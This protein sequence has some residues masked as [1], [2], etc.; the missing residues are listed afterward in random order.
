MR[1][2]LAALGLTLLSVC[3]AACGDDDAVP[4]VSTG[5]GGDEDED[6]GRSDAGPPSPRPDGGSILPPADSELELPFQGPTQTFQLSGEASL[7]MLDVHLSVD[8]S[9]SID[10]EIDELQDALDDEI[11]PDLRDVVPALCVGVSR[12]EDFPRP[13]FGNTKTSAH[14]ADRPYELLTAITS[15]RSAIAAA[16]SKLDLPLGIGGDTPEAGAEALYQ[17]ATG[18][19]YELNDRAVIKPFDGDAAHGGGEI[20]G[21]GFR[22]GALH[23]V[24][25]ITDA[26]AHTPADYEADF[27]DTH[28]LDD[29]A[30][31]LVAIDARVVSI[32]SSVCEKED[33]GDSCDDRFPFEARRELEKLAYETGAVTAPDDDDECPTGIEGA[34]HEP[35]EGVCPL[36]FDVT[37]Q[38][39]GLVESFTSAITTLV[40]D[41]R[42][43]RVVGVAA[44]DPLGLVESIRPI[45]VSD[46]APEIADLLP[47]GAPDGRPDTF[48]NARA[49]APIVFE[50]RLRNVRL[51]PRDEPQV[52]RVVLQIRGDDLI[53]DEQ[54]LRIT[55]PAGTL[56]PPPD[57]DAGR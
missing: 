2:V 51:P 55:V 50:V 19:G 24:L 36:V 18:E 45:A 42:F 15:S 3:A 38:G 41:I 17:I 8:T 5:D 28:S 34:A 14:R 4:S 33:R 25:H 26:P 32:V 54:T 9:A 29:A 37:D 52:F 16:V 53:V 27:P 31:A 21:V 22:P 30:K 44:N 6:G 46:E 11:L 35:Y 12:F 23:V 47:S 1:R 48:V 49:G 10:S 57:E 43:S 13:P 20:G 40:N 39:D 56:P 7:G